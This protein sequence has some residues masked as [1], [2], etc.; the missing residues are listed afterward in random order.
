LIDNLFLNQA[1]LTQAIVQALPQQIAE[2]VAW[3]QQHPDPNHTVIDLLY[4]LEFRL[5]E[6]TPLPPQMSVF[7]TPTPEVVH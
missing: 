5:E 6:L 3:Y 7:T 1:P 4:D 2:M